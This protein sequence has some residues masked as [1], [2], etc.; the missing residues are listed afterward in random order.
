MMEPAG[1]GAASINTMWWVLL[2]VLTVVFLIVMAAMGV[3]LFHRRDPPEPGA[4]RSGADGPEVERRRVVVV[5]TAGAFIPI[6][7]LT[8]IF[9]YTMIVLAEVGPSNPEG[10]LTVEVTGKQFWWDVTY[11]LPTGDTVRTANEIHIPVGERVTLLLESDDVI[12]SLWVPKLHGKTDM[13]PGRTN[14][15]WLQADEPGV[16][17]GQC[18]EYCGEQHTWMALLVVAEPEAEFRAWLQRQ[19]R[20]AAPVPPAWDP[21]AEAMSEPGP[22]MTPADSAVARRRNERIRSGREVYLDP[23]HRC[24]ACHVIRGVGNGAPGPADQLMAGPDLTHVASRRMLAAGL[25]EM[26][27]GNMAGWVANP[28]VLKPGNLMPRIPLEPD[29]LNA[30]V[31]YLMS[32]Q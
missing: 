12:H 10:A 5:L 13:I 28:Q 17:R 15:M 2:A 4:G 9:V 8:G 6:V 29:E 20:P 1:P 3:A 16:Y 18:A 23:E 11:M 19:R 27:R 24:T 26:N 31:D 21:A 7:I 25:L 14:E 30:L 22:E 32:L